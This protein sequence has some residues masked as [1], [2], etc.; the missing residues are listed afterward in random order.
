MFWPITQPNI[1]IFNDCTKIIR[2]VLSND[3][4]H[5]LCLFYVNYSL[6]VDFMVNKPSKCTKLG[7]GT[8]IFCLGR[9][10][11]LKNTKNTKKD[12]NI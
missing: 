11:F 3:I 5:I 10:R 2:S 12:Q 4:V 9:E 8:N 7:G 6:D 1:N